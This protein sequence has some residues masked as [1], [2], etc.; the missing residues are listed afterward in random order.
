M[1]GL[2]LNET[3]QGFAFDILHDDE[4]AIFFF[5]DFVDCADVW[6]VKRRSG[7]S[8][9]IEPLP[10]LWVGRRIGGEKLDGDCD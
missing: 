1:Q 6:M 3:R 4:A 9:A 5:A 8:F 7:L 10:C 2:A